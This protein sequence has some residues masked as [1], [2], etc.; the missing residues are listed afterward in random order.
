MLGEK[1]TLQWPFSCALTCLITEAEKKAGFIPY[2]H[3]QSLWL[4]LWSCGVRDHKRQN[5]SHA[6]L[7]KGMSTEQKERKKKEEKKKK[8]AYCLSLCPP[9]PLCSKRQ[10]G[11]W[12]AF[13]HH[14]IL[15]ALLLK[16]CTTQFSPA[17]LAE[18]LQGAGVGLR[19]EAGGRCALYEPAGEGGRHTELETA[20]KAHAFR[21]WGSKMGTKQGN[22]QRELPPKKINRKWAKFKKSLGFNRTMHLLKICIGSLI[23]AGGTAVFLLHHEGG[24]EIISGNHSVF[25][26]FHLAISGAHLGQAVNSTTG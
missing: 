18:V 1:N 13:R 17:E 15:P 26:L 12:Q 22:W 16:C 14:L 23:H 10:A 19:G 8:V 2:S 24:W 9:P 25:G 6:A 20:G 3:T 11:V 7:Q 5:T 4:Q 21:G